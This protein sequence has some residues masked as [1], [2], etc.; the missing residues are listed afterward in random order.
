[1]GAESAGRTRRS[2]VAGLIAVLALVVGGCGGGS[3]SVAVHHP[4][5][6][7]DRWT[8]ARALFRVKCAGCH[9]LADA[10]AHGRRSDLDH[11]GLA[12]APHA[13]AIARRV[14]LHGGPG[15]PVEEE[16]MPPE[17]F[18]ALARYVAAVAGRHVPARP[19]V[20][21]TP[22]PARRDRFV[23]ARTLFDEICASCHRL[24]DAGARSGYVDM[25]HSPLSESTQRPELAR[26]VMR[27][28]YHAGMPAFK[29]ILT[30]REFNALVD[31]VAAVA[32]APGAR[33]G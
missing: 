3:A 6:P 25:D 4:R 14:M 13:T 7:H 22:V 20:R 28:G 18:D 15:M 10:G 8:H 16:M 29:G 9:A 5:L 32:G 2:S 24:A 26:F 31:Y 1:M 19:P 33:G 27:H 21:T 11:S 17:D 12:Y 23:Y 30:E